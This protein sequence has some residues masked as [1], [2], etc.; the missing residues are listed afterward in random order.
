MTNDASA[1]QTSLELLARKSYSEQEIRIKL[2]YKGYDSQ[3]VDQ[4]VQYLLRRGY[5]DDTALCHFW[6]DK[7]L[8]TG[9]YGLRLV[10]K[11]LKQ[12]GIATDTINQVLQEYEEVNEFETAFILC[13]K[14]FRQN[15]GLQL[16][17]LVR[18]LQ[19]RGFSQETIC[20]VWDKLRE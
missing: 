10:I 8:H 19:Y 5:L 17:K 15:H 4:V 7:Y 13:T 20:R 14:H 6:A 16:A 9:K 2:E 18:F 3:I 11:K 12:R 1:L